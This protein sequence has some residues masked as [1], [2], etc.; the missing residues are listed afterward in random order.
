MKTLRDIEKIPPDEMIIVERYYTPWSFTSWYIIA[1]EA[2]LAN[3]QRVLY[4]RPIDAVGQAAKLIDI[5][6]YG[7]IVSDDTCKWDY[8]SMSELAAIH[9][10]CNM[11]VEQDV[12]FMPQTL[13]CWCKWNL[14]EVSE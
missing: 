6:F 5:C 1:G 11:Q 10:P 12:H 13:S 9:G 7:I 2:L 4:E 8:F 3:G 14:V